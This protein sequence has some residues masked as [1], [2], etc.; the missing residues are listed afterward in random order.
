[1]PHQVNDL[2]LVDHIELDPGGLA[3]LPHFVLF[4]IEIIKQLIGR[5]NNASVANK[6]IDETDATSDADSNQVQLAIRAP[7]DP[8][9]LLAKVDLAQASASLNLPNA[10]GAIVT[11]RHQVLTTLVNRN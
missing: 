3:R 6:G 4:S 9:D 1:M 11:T 8:L 10:H 7:L 5:I 2:G